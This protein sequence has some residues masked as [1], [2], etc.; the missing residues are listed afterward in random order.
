[1]FG[2]YLGSLSNQYLCVVDQIVYILSFI[3][4]RDRIFNCK[5]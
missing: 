2:G 1:M 4:G 5:D 3:R